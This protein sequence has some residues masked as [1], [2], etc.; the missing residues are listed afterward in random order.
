MRFASVLRT[1][2][3]GRA[4]PI[5]C[6]FLQLLS[7][8]PATA[9]LRV[10]QRR[11]KAQPAPTNAHRP[12]RPR[13]R[14]GATE[15]SIRSLSPVGRSIAHYGPYAPTLRPVPRSTHPLIPDSVKLQHHRQRGV[16]L[17]DGQPAAPTTAYRPGPPLVGRPASSNPPA[18][19]SP[20]HRP[21]LPMRKVAASLW[22][23]P[24]MRGPL[25][26]PHAPTA[27]KPKQQL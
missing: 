20:P 10:R 8:S 14:I 15:P 22:W 16:T 25:A 2:P 26:V 11:Q 3:F 7:D 6:A 17:P 13:L 12:R 19:A 21:R 27:S 1:T 23:A 5:P 18:G 24:S 9:R 4:L